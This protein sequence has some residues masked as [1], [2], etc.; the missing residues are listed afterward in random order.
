MFC[1]NNDN[2]YEPS[3]SVYERERYRRGIYYLNVDGA[4]VWYK[5]DKIHRED[6][7][8]AIITNTN[9]MWMKNGK[10]HRENGKPAVVSNDGFKAWCINDKYHRDGDEP[11]IDSREAKLWFKNGR[12]HRDGKKPAVIYINGNKEYWVNG[13]LMSTEIKKRSITVPMKIF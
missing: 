10:R 5:D 13:V 12:K 4:I 6:D 7:E 3:I 8:P 1:N 2:D 9:Q 11:A